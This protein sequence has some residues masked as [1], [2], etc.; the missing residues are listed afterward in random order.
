MTPLVLYTSPISTPK[1]ITET[2][3]TSGRGS[4]TNAAGIYARISTIGAHQVSRTVRVQPTMRSA[5]TISASGVQRHTAASAAAASRISAS[6]PQAGRRFPRRL[7]PFGMR[8]A[9]LACAKEAQ[10]H[11]QVG[12]HL[13][14]RFGHRR[15]FRLHRRGL[16]HAHAGEG[17]VLHRTAGVP[18]RAGV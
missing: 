2:S 15:L 10:A 11:A 3:V 13:L 16:D 12:D 5:V 8:L 9:R 18:D 17:D 4:S 6:L 7:L 14:H 1:V